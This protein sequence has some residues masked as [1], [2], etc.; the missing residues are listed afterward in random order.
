[1]NYNRYKRLREQVSTN[2]GITWTDTGVYKKGDLIDTGG[3][4]SK[5]DCEIGYYPPYSILYS[6]NEFESR[7][8]FTFNNLQTLIYPQP[9][10][11]NELATF[12]VGDKLTSLSGF[13]QG[14]TNLTSVEFVGEWDC[15]YIEDI[16]SMFRNCTNIKTIKGIE[17]LNTENATTMMSMFNSCDSLTELDLSS[18]NTEKVTSVYFMF[19]NCPSLEKLDL[20]SFVMTK[21]NNMSNMFGNC[22]SL[23]YIKCTQAFK[24][25][26]EKNKNSIYLT[27][28]DTIQWDI[29]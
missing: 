10:K 27:N 19:Y 22:P 17:K 3:W 14:I 23:N 21:V 6:T 4:D 25:W 12:L 11:V 16:V 9:N 15:T 5:E 2:G 1:M 8:T 26:C 29:V 20:S 18:F 7:Y 28:F 24:D 13:C